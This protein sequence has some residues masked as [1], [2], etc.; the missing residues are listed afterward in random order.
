MTTQGLPAVINAFAS[1]HWIFGATLCK[2]YGCLGGIFGTV[3]ICTMVVIGYDRYNVICRGFNGV[4]INFCTA[5]AIIVVL[6]T[7]GIVGCCPPFWGWGGYALGNLVYFNIIND[8]L[9]TLINISN[10]LE[11]LFMTCSYD[12]FT[13]DWNHKSYILYAFINNYLFPMLCVIFF[14]SQIVKAVVSHEAALK[15][16]A[17]KMNVDSLRS[18]VVSIPICYYISYIID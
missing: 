5:V 15:K 12:F 9:V 18:N 2:V 6:W 17:K 10:F 8:Y 13:D 7:Y 3:S 16:Q 4:K 1:D 14:Y 11:G